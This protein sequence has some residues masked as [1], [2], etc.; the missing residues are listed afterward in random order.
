MS[1]RQLPAR[2][3]ADSHRVR[4]IGAAR[5][6]DAVAARAEKNRLDALR[7]AATV[8]Y[9]AEQIGIQ[10]DV[11]GALALCADGNAE[12]CIAALRLAA[13]REDATE[14]HVVTPGPILPTRE[15]LA[16]VLLLDG[17]PAAAVQEYM[18]VLD[19]EPNRYRAVAGAMRAA[20]LS[21]DPHAARGF[22]G[23]L[24]RQSVNAD[25]DRTSLAQARVMI[26]NQ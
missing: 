23:H 22:A 14:K 8:P 2:R 15:L 20:V 21:G 1:T 26:D 25:M 17:Q 10:A 19:K 12:G 6:G 4:G 11:V 18:T 24:V 3:A 13:V 9:W 5:A 16:D 7:A